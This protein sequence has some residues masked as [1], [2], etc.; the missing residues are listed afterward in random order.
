MLTFLGFVSCGAFIGM[1]IHSVI[2]LEER[3]YY[4]ARDVSRIFE[5]V[6]DILEKISEEGKNDTRTA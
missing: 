1:L 2:R 4:L 6:V 5:D 3:V